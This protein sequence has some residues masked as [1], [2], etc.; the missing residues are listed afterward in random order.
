MVGGFGRSY[1]S[2]N[3]KRFPLPS[4]IRATTVYSRIANQFRGSNP[5][6]KK[7]SLISCTLKDLSHRVGEEE[8]Q[9]DN[10]EVWALTGSSHWRSN[11]SSPPLYG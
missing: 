4:H 9:Q 3:A 8:L 6:N 2:L 7:G 1:G 11:S 5:Q 10:R